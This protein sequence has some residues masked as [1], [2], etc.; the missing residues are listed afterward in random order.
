[1]EAT[2]QTVP[3]DSVATHRAWTDDLDGAFD[4]PVFVK[5]PQADQLFERAAAIGIDE[6]V[7]RLDITRATFMSIGKGEV[8]FMNAATWAQALERL[9]GVEYS[10]E[11][12][13]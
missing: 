10:V 9:E 2:L 5:H 8:D 7:R 11:V 3:V 13:P 1:M 12:T 6:A 4:D